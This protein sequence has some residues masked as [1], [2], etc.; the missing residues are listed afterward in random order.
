MGMIYIIGAEISEGSHRALNFAKNQARLISQNIGSILVCVAGW[1]PYKFQNSEE[2]ENRRLKKIEEVYFA[3]KTV[4]EPLMKKLKEEIFN[5][6]GIVAH[7]NFVKVLNEVAS[8]K[9]ADQIFISRFSTSKRKN[10]IS[11]TPAQI[12][13]SS[14]IP[15]TIVN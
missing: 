13:F 2:N 3:N 11:D 12:I 15:V 10:K 14:N 9:S 6:E 7:G 4:I 1:S 5:V 8:K